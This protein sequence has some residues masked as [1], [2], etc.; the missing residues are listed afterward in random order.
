MPSRTFIGREEKSLSGF[1]ASKDRRSL[2]LGADAAGDFRRKSM[3]FYP[4]ENPTV[5]KNY[6]KS[7]LLVL[8]KRNNK[9]WMTAHLFITWFTEYF[10]PIVETCYSEK[11]IRFKIWLFTGNAPGH[12]R[13]LMEMNTEIH[14]IFMPA[15]KTSIL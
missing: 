2:L 10:Q 8:S 4:S 9:G 7:T 3:L 5:L 1:Q 15:N 12:P 6:A 14:V 11:K 13:A